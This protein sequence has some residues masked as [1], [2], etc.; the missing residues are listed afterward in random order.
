VTHGEALRLQLSLPWLSVDMRRFPGLLR[1]RTCTTREPGIQHS[2]MMET[3][4]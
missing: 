4:S 1:N 3:T 2:E